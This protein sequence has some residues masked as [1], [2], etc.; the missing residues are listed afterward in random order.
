MAS[1]I[2]SKGS[3][4]AS[5][6]ARKGSVAGPSKPRRSL[7]IAASCHRRVMG[8]ARSAR[9]GL[10]VPASVGPSRGCWPV[11]R[12][13]ISRIRIRLAFD[14][15]LVGQ[16]RQSL[17]RRPRSCASCDWSTRNSFVTS[18]RNDPNVDLAALVSDAMYQGV[19]QH[20]YGQ[21]PRVIPRVLR[22]SSD[23]TQGV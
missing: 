6:K 15:G 5:S 17:G 2:T 23:S 22:G 9:P 4:V 21:I 11:D 13:L 20:R 18:P 1:S 8:C 7:T 10:G 12:T 16:H 19:V 14:L 3:E